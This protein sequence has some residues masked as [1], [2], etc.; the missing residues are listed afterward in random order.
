MRQLA[1]V[2]LALVLVAGCGL[3]GYLLLRSLAPR[4]DRELNRMLVASNLEVGATSAAFL[5][6]TFSRRSR[7]GAIGGGV[8]FAISVLVSLSLPPGDYLGA[9]S[10]GGLLVGATFGSALSARRSDEPMTGDVRVA[11]SNR[12]ACRST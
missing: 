12:T 11:L 8:G 2:P 1:L 4:G 6:P 7:W 10:A 9:F 5:R 3:F